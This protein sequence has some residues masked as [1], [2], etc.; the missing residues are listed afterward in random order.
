MEILSVIPNAIEQGVENPVTIK[1]TGFENGAT[2][3]ISGLGVETED[4][5]VVDP[6]TITLMIR[7]SAG[8]DVGF[9]DVTVTLP[10]ATTA[11]LA[12]SLVVTNFQSLTAQL[13]LLIGERIKVGKTEADTAFSDDELIDMILRHNG[14]IYLAAAEAWSAKQADYS[15]L[16]DISES[17]SERKLSQMFKNANTMAE[18]Y[19]K[20]GIAIGAELINPVVGQSVAWLNPADDPRAFATPNSA[21]P[22]DD[23]FVFLFSQAFRFAQ[24]PWYPVTI[25]G[26]V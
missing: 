8:A 1:G 25:G 19:S 22:F 2:V 21:D 17:G 11:G 4:V 13:R 10:D 18:A 20:A 26:V 6:E 9:R 14:N 16:V 7:V 12:G 15:K 5:I 24:R 3:A 23:P